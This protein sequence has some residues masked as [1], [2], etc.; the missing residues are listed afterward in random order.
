MA[1]GRTAPLRGRYGNL[2]GL[3]PLRE[4][5][6]EL[7]H[8]RSEGF[9]HEYQHQ[10][11]AGGRILPFVFGL[12]LSARLIYAL[13]RRFRST[14][15]DVSWGHLVAADGSLVSPECDIILHRGG[16]LA[17]QWN[18]C[19]QSPVMD[20]HFVYCTRSLAVVSCKSFVRSVDGE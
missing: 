5:A 20:F 17:G 16:P 2:L 15:V 19:T 8:W 1:P 9:T 14:G 13:R 11:E 3:E 10:E 6:A 12:R 4:L 18:D 7:L